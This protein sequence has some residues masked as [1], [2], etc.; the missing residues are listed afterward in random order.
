MS[1]RIQRYFLSNSAARTR[2]R[3]RSTGPTVPRLGVQKMA[4]ERPSIATIP[5]TTWNRLKRCMLRSADICWSNADAAVGGIP[6]PDRTVIEAMIRTFSDPSEHVRHKR[7]L[8][9][10]AQVAS[11]SAKQSL[12]TSGREKVH[13]NTK[14]WARSKPTMKM[15]CFPIDRSF[16]TAT[17]SCSM[18]RS[19]CTN[20]TSCTSCCRAGICT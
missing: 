11:A 12:H 18:M 15:T 4:E 20:S 16:C 19:K 13:G 8:H 9:V 10:I 14:R 3:A 7:W 17:G 2:L 5:K 1:E 6:E